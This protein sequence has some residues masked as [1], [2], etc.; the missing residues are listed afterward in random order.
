MTQFPNGD[1]CGVG[2]VAVP[3][4]LGLVYPSGGGDLIPGML[5]FGFVAVGVGDGGAIGEM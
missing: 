2:D 3:G 5:G 1:R 4:P